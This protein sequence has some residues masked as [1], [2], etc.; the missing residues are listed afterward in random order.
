MLLQGGAAY[1]FPY[2]PPDSLGTP[3]FEKC[4]FSDSEPPYSKDPKP[5]RNWK[6]PG[7]G[8]LRNPRSGFGVQDS[9]EFGSP[10][11]GVSVKDPKLN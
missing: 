1:K 5:L 9:L 4:D 6:D 3:Y 10:S 7:F 2:L 11:P 8:G